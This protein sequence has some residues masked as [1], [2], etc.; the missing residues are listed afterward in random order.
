M[1]IKTVISLNKKI[2]NLNYKIKEQSLGEQ[3]IEL[4]LWAFSLPITALT[5]ILF[6]SVFKYNIFLGL[7]SIITIPYFL[8]KIFTYDKKERSEAFKNISEHII[9][10]NIKFNRKD[11]I[12]KESDNFNKEELSLLKI[13]NEENK[14]HNASHFTIFEQKI[15]EYS[16]DA[17]QK[18]LQFILKSIN[19]EKLKFKIF[20]INQVKQVEKNEIS[21]QQIIKS[22]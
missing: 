8:Y 14:N 19:K 5:F 9:K 16:K 21:K 2:D 20:E 22:I 17:N 3:F 13:L 10:N 11:I 4:S 15:L 12:E 18:D 6:S 1:N 7:I